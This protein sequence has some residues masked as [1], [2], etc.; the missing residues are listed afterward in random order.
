[1]TFHASTTGACVPPSRVHPPVYASVVRRQKASNTSGKSAIDQHSC[2]AQSEAR[3]PVEGA[4]EVSQT[5]QKIHESHEDM[6]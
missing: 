4:E 3:A 1:M 2:S 6:I 5:G